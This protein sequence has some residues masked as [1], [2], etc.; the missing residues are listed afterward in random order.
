MLTHHPYFLA[1]EVPDRD[2]GADESHLFALSGAGKI[3]PSSQL[4]LSGGSKAHV[5]SLGWLPGWRK[6]VFTRV[7]LGFGGKSFF[8]FSVLFKAKVV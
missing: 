2:A 3:A 4:A 7:G 1:Q 5:R 8:L 6:V